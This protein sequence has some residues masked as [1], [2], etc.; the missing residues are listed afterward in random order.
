LGID[1]GTVY[2]ERTEQL[3][4]GDQVLFYTDGITEATN[5]AGEMFGVERL[6]RVPGRSLGAS[7]RRPGGA[8]GIYR[9]QAAG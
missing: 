4:P 5:A 8:G 9:G 2:C 3:Q 6:G 1:T 7:P